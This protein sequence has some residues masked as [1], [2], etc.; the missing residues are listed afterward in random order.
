MKKK[1]LI[2]GGSGFIGQ[3]LCRFFAI[4]QNTEVTATYL[5][6]SPSQI[7][8][9]IWKKVNFFDSCEANR[10]FH[11]HY[12][13]VIN[14]AAVTSGSNITFLNPEIHVL[15]NIKMNV[16]IFEAIRNGV[17]PSKYIFLSCTVMYPSSAEYH[18]ESEVIDPQAINN[19]YHGIAITKV[20]LEQLCNFYSRQIPTKFIAL[21]HSNIYGPYD[22]FNLESGHVLASLLLKARAA[23]SSLEIW[24]DG[25]EIRDFLYISDFLSAI[26]II[27]S[28]YSNK[29]GIYNLGSSSPCSIHQLAKK[30]ISTVN[31]NLSLLQTESGRQIK[32]DIKIDSS[33]FSNEFSWTPHV[34][35]DEGL[36]KTYEWL[37]TNL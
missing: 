14:A 28:E 10:L 12:D 17:F 2:L 9:V 24:G 27:D 1:I 20:Y 23:E 26:E 7:N 34:R 11:S 31:P 33:K 35:L 6:N 8:N 22:K 21:R 18:K 19:R 32:I 29:F 25:S 30:I 13:L 5:N 36:S 15:S 3:S 37:N 4:K 16:N